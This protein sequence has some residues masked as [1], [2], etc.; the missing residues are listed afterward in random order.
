M[1]KL[2]P[3]FSAPAIAKPVPTLQMQMQHAFH[4]HPS[5]LPRS[6]EVER[7]NRGKRSVPAV[8]APLTACTYD[9]HVLSRGTYSTDIPQVGTCRLI[10]A[11][12]D[13]ATY[14]NIGGS[15]LGS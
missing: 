2:P 5:L 8:G 9:A 13:C 12:W 3:F 11:Y 6:R 10:S 1:K 7:C 4:G 14:M 15:L